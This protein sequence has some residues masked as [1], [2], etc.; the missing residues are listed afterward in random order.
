M[1][2]RSIIQ[3]DGHGGAA[4]W[5]VNMT[6][7]TNYNLKM[8]NNFKMETCVDHS[9]IIFSCEFVYKFGWSN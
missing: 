6:D 7:I 4:K 9:V 8:D 1:L 2:Y 3:T 5:K